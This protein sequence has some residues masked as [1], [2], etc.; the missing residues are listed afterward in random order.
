M[1]EPVLPEQL[2][3]PRLFDPQ[4]GPVIFLY[5]LELELVLALELLRFAPPLPG[6]RY[7]LGVEFRVFNNIVKTVLFIDCWRP[8]LFGFLQ[9]LQIRQHCILIV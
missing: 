3:D 2:F 6:S 8:I 9:R 7:F 4:G 1:L 5:L